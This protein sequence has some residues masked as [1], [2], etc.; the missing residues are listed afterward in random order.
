MSVATYDAMRT[1]WTGRA[2]SSLTLVQRRGSVPGHQVERGWVVGAVIISRSTE[3]WLPAKL[4][5]ITDH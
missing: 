1:S 2:P 3:N 5:Q 4:D